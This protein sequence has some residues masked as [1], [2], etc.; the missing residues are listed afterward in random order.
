MNI[1][2]LLT[3]FR[4][5][6]IPVFALVFFSSSP[7]NLLLSLFIFLAAGLTDVLDGYIARK[8]NL[9]TKWGIVLDPLADK[10]MLLTV[11][12]CLVIRSYA[13]VWILIIVAAKELFLI[14]GGMVLLKKN[15][16]IPSNVFG[17]FSTILFYL[18]IFVI[19]FGFR[20]GD[21]ML[22]IAV[23][24]AVVALVNYLVIFL[25]NR[26]LQPNGIE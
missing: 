20:F 6:L 17:K 5:L 19:S 12:T 14:G 24:S 9:V 7:N 16:V 15:T 10:L 25:R 18:S 4:L 8:Y 22:Y 13:P 2:N 23:I 26:G 3:L 21:Y 1:P 11:L